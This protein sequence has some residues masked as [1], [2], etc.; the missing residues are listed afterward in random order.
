MR[1][2]LVLLSV[3]SLAAALFSAEPPKLQEPYQ[4]IV[5]LTAAAPPEFAADAL[6]RVVE[7]GKLA[8]QNARRTLIE[9]AF[10]L[11]GSAKFAVRMEGLPGATGDTLSSSLSHSYA[12]KLDVLSLQSRAVRDMLPLDRG[13]ARELFQ[14]I[15]RPTFAPLSCDDALIYEPSDYYQALIAVVNGAFTPTEKSKDEHIH[16]L[17]DSL[18]Q[19]TSA[20]QLAPG[21]QAVKA[22]VGT[23]AQNQMLWARFNSLLESM[24][25]DDRSFAAS[26]AALSGLGLPEI[27]AS[28]EKYRQKSHG[29]ESDT[30]TNQKKASTPKLVLYWQSTNS[31][32]LLAAGQKL[33]FNSNKQLLTDADRSTTEWQQQLADY[34]N[35]IAGWTSDQESSDEVY[36]H[37][38]CIVYTALLELVPSGSQND[39]I[40]ADYVDFISGSGL[41]QESPAEWFVEPRMLLDRFQSS[42]AQRSKVLAAYQ[43][44]G[45]PVLT[46]EV[47]LEKTLSGNLPSWAISEK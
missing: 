46:L 10:H 39:K 19:A 3:V 45:N 43:N 18:G 11:A 8:D 42:Q 13:K 22:F 6:L 21:A 31:Q 1:G 33:R 35:L 14:E 26:L 37:E 23:S 16:L 44:S 25:P 47:A 28:L 12:L 17:L 34:L 41:Y 36:Y 32:Q 29:C 9:Q 5:N 40:L 38:K 2:S 7:W 27:Q 24:Q 20:G 30:P 15:I 4:S